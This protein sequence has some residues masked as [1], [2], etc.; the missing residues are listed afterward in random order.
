MA[1]LKSMVILLVKWRKWEE[2]EIEG[3]WSVQ[4]GFAKVIKVFLELGFKWLNDTVTEKSGTPIKQGATS[5][6]ANSHPLT[7]RF[8]WSSLAT[9]NKLCAQLHAVPHHTIKDGKCCETIKSPCLLPPT[10]S[11]N[12]IRKVRNFN[13][14]Q[15]EM[16]KL[17]IWCTRFETNYSSL[18]QVG[19]VKTYVAAVQWRRSGKKER[20]DEW[21]SVYHQNWWKCPVIYF[22]S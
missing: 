22:V 4:K 9:P 21:N 1:L 5:D 2:E 15:Y 11:F 7:R 12:G 6:E 10:L 20:Q 8:L 17:S 3:N 19:A 14:S 13:K 18:S 16:L